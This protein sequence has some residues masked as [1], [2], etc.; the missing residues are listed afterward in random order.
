MLY[1]LG[2][3]KIGQC[4]SFDNMIFQHDFSESLNSLHNFFRSGQ[5]GMDAAV[6]SCGHCGVCGS[7]GDFDCRPDSVR[8][9]RGDGSVLRVTSRLGG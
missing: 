1:I 4:I 6:C 3:F 9:M 2:D 5:R 7:R 8:R